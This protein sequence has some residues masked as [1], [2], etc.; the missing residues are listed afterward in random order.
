M[1]P[2]EAKKLDRVIRLPEVMRRTTMS[3]TTISRMIAKGQFPKP[4]KIA[5]RAC[6]WL[7]SEIDKWFEN[8]KGAKNETPNTTEN[9]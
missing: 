2:I 5:E 9:G 1:K 4:A 7:E 6:G 8:L 3:R